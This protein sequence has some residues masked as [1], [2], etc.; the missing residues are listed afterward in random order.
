[1]RIASH[2][3]AIGTYAIDL[4]AFTPFLFCFRDREHIM[5]LLEWISGAR[6][7]Y[8]Y[9]WIGGLAYDV[10]ADFKKRVAEFVAYFK[11]K[12][13][14]LY[15]LLT[16]NEIFVKRTYDIGIMPADVAIWIKSLKYWKPYLPGKCQPDSLVRANAQNL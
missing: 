10:P 15:Q 11:P 9:I 8:N 5:S 1:M 2:L 3:V 12:A 4:G 16:E 7:L 14:E 13:K 6:M